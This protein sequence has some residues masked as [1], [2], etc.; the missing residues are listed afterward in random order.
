MLDLER[1]MRLVQV[2][3]ENESQVIWG[4]GKESVEANAAAQHHEK[5]D[6]VTSDIV[7]EVTILWVVAELFIYKYL[8][9]R[10][11]EFE[12][13]LSLVGLHHLLEFRQRDLSNR[14][15]FITCGR[16]VRITRGVAQRIDNVLLKGSVVC[17]Q[18]IRNLA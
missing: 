9:A 6:V 13:S 18:G 12:R 2:Q 1:T 17:Q 16:S 11:E 3:V 14:N 4:V 8:V 10:T 5:V 15:I 7:R